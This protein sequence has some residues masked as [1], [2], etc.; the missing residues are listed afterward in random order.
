MVRS[1]SWLVLPLLVVLAGCAPALTVTT[2]FDDQREAADTLPDEAST[3]DG[4]E[5]AT[6]RLLWEGDGVSFYATRGEGDPGTLLCLVAVEESGPAA[7]CSGRVPI[8]MTA[9]G[10]EGSFGEDSPGADWVE[11]APHFWTR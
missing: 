4:I 3:L 10:V 11:R 5:P 1:R 7:A 2:I 6:S 8:T 9:A